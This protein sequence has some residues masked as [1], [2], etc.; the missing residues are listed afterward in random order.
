[1]SD[2]VISVENVSKRYRLGLIGGGTLSADLERWWAR[3]RGKPDPLLK[4][5]QEDYANRQDEH[6]WALRDVSFEVQQ[7]EVLAYRPQ[8]GG[9]DHPAQDPFARHSP[10]CGTGQGE[11]PSG[12]PAGGLP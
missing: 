9:E 3:V 12:Q 5:G 2:I 7:G 11:G 8:R 4:I 6:I 1:M 10:H